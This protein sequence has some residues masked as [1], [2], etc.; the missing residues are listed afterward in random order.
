MGDTVKIGP[1]TVPNQHLGIITKEHGKVFNLPF[2]GLLGLSL[3]ELALRKD[4]T[5]FDNVMKTTRLAENQF[6][7]YFD[8]RDRNS[9]IL[10]GT[11]A[12]EYFRPPIQ[13]IDID[14]RTPGYWQVKMKDI[15]VITSDGKE[16]A[17]N[18][19]SDEP[20]KA[21]ADTGTSLLTAPTKYL[22]TLLLEF[23]PN[24]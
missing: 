13:F 6:S 4:I 24:N 12:R 18:F 8:R 16:R 23:S 20:C 17:L 21:V 14:Q 5:L 7:F 9:K 3:P 15:Y 11:P 19:C 1:L 22:R 10:F 2:E